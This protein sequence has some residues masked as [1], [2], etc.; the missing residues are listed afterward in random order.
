[1]LIFHSLAQARYRSPD[2]TSFV[3]HRKAL[4]TESRG[5]AVKDR[6]RYLTCEIEHRARDNDVSGQ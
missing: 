4:D 5:T 1:M 3:E 6:A 2:Q